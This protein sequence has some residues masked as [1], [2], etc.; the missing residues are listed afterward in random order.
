[1]TPTDRLSPR[2]FRYAATGVLLVAAGWR[3]AMAA[4]LP[5]ISRDGVTFCWFARDLGTQG[6]SYLRD[7]AADQHPLFPASIL[8]VQYI[9]RALGAPDSPLTWQRSGQAVTLLAGLAVI[10][11][12]GALTARLSRRLDLPLAPRLAAL[13]AMA[14]AAALDLNVW[15]SADVMSEQL[16]LAFYLGAVLLLVDGLPALRAALTCGLL[17]GLAFLTRQEG[18]VP[19]LAGCATLF[20]Q[21]RGVPA[22]R[23][24]GRGLAVL[25]GFLV[26]ALPYWVTVGRFSPKKDVFDWFRPH[27]P[28]ATRAAGRALPHQVV[29]RAG[30][31]CPLSIGE[32]HGRHGR[33]TREWFEEGRCRH[34]RGTHEMG[35]SRRA[36][37]RLRTLDLPWYAVLPT[38]LERLFRAGRYVVPLLALLP[39]VTLRRPLIRGLAG[40]TTCLAGHLTLATLLLARHGYLDPRHMLVAVML[41][42]PLAA[43]QL[44]RLV[45][46][47]LDVRRR[48]PAAVLVGA[49]LLPFAVYALRV[50]NADDAHLREAADWLR[51]QPDGAGRVLLGGS[52]TRRIAFYSDLVWQPWYEDPAD[53][54]ILVRRIRQAGPGYL[55][56]EI[57]RGFEREEN[58]ALIARLRSDPAAACRLGDAREFPLRDGLLLLIT[59]RAPGP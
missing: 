23:L 38:A 13:L 52:S 15:L 44:T 49:A 47:L 14:L 56:L 50:P 2:A 59:L 25:A 39:L 54:D 28:A 51:A 48:V 10:A 16:H 33:G 21:R 58:A 32:Q 53:Y 29:A 17:A 40:Y 3:L 19:V 34:G 43:M 57:G 42:V 9:A 55:A 12:S 4:A 41:L 26:L 18:F 27:S 20:A 1:M 8:T 46:L 7:P 45:A 36:L 6:L 24:A 35:V 30:R 5:V 11:L 31:P 22:R 37:A